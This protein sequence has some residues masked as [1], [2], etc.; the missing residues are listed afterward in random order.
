RSRTMTHLRVLGELDIID[1]TG[2]PLA[3]LVTQPK[4][5]SLLVYLALAAPP[6][7]KRRDTLLALFWPELDESRARAALN[8][9]LHLLRKAIGS[10]VIVS[11]G[12]E[13]G[14]DRD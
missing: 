8:K 3:A 11:R 14:L 12:D 7:F 13:V 10:Q 2:Q 1:A 4:R 6:G 9:T 5:V